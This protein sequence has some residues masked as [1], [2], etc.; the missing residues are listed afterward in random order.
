MNHFY[1]LLTLLF[2]GHA[3]AYAQPGRPMH[4][5]P[6]PTEVQWG[7]GQ[8]RI[9]PSFTMSISGNPDARLYAEATRALRRLDNRTGLFFRQ[10]I[11]GPGDQNPQA[12]L[13]LQVER[14][15]VL[16]LGE[17]EAYQLKI[18]AQ[19]AVI[20]ATT[21][22]GAIHGLET[23]LQLLQG[24]RNGY[25][26]PAC[27]ISDNP[28]FPWRGLMMDPCRHFMP[29]DVIMRTID[30]MSAV[31]LNVLH[32]HLS[33]DQGFRV[34]SKKYP[35][36]HEKGSQGL[37]YTQE[38]VRKLVAYAGQRG[39]RVVPEFGVPGHTTAML[40]AYPHLG[41]KR[42]DY[43]IEKY[44]GIFDPSLDPTNEAVY[45][46]LDTLFGE[47]S[48]LFPDAYFHIGGDENTGLHWDEN[49]DIQ[50]FMKANGIAD[51]HELQTHFNKKILEIL[52]KY[53]RKMMG[54]DEIL[55]PGVPKDIVIQSWRGKEAL[56]ESAKMGYQGLLSNGYYIDL[57]Q[58]TDFH[59]LNDPLPPNSG[60]TPE[61][62]ARILG[63][64]ATMWSEHVTPETVDSRIWPRTAA[65][66]ER[67]WSPTTV[68]DL[69]DMYRRMDA[70]S[71]YLEGEGA[72]HLRN[73]GVLLRRLCNGYDT[74]PL[75]TLVDV[76]E[77]LKIYQRN[78]GDTMYTIYSPYT[79]L[80]DVA[81]PDQ[82]VP[83]LFNE[84]AEQYAKTL[85]P[86]LG[87]EVESFLVLWAANHSK[88]MPIIERSPVLREAESLSANL[89]TIANLG[90]QAMKAIQTRKKAKEDWVYQALG[91][92][93]KARE[94]GGRCDL[95]VVSGI[96][97]LIRKAGEINR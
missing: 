59:Y 41:S 36:L 35:L 71:L 26:F 85:D 97:S 1:S 5:M 69:P 11:L 29:M 57:I 16:E 32:M 47:M 84:K 25:F 30:L 50:A 77:P 2:V 13:F 95:Q 68:R 39:I 44:F 4:L 9:G 79:K 90:L 27:T 80:A 34:E 66:A 46:F 15:G 40:T 3:L 14:P 61:E 62:A 72:T 12:T 49:P 48:S 28:R 60:L 58:P 52:K 43:E 17:D 64:E 93:A 37:Y 73:K 6:V 86:A 51:N 10:G 53:N 89:A 65:I 38:E 74:G 83:R 20:T 33:Q 8:L 92:T 45:T 63:G 18:S 96:E 55:Q 42:M 24:D 75:E 19:Q 81:T 54:W 88:L 70:V 7:D 31:K 76:I 91:I 82:R 23:F 22:L 67:F 87:R 78:Q 21:D 94:Q 56:Y